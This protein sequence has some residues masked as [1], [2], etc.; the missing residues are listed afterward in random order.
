MLVGG[1][2]TWRFA[3]FASLAGYAAP[4]LEVVALAGLLLAAGSLVLGGRVSPTAP[5]DRTPDGAMRE[6]LR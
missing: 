1:D 6:L 3:E 5:A 2:A 4:V